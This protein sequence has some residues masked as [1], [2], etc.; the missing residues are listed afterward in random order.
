MKIGEIERD[1]DVG[2]GKAKNFFGDYTEGALVKEGK[3]LYR[4]HPEYK[5]LEN[6][7]WVKFYKKRKIQT[8]NFT[9]LLFALTW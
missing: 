1:I 6:D 9:I 4:K 2:R 5:Y 8:M 3:R 7:P